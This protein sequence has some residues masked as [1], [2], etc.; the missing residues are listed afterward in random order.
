MLVSGR[1]KIEH[2]RPKLDF[3]HDVVAASFASAA[4][5]R[6]MPEDASLVPKPLGRQV[7]GRQVLGRQALREDRPCAALARCCTTAPAATIARPCRSIGVR[8]WA[9]AWRRSG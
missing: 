7:L 6:M 5:L 2:C 3:N 9:A 4:S 8:S 1:R